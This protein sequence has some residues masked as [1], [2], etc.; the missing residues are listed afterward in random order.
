M[1]KDR[2]ETRLAGG[3]GRER[4][5]PTTVGSVNSDIEVSVIWLQFLW[6]HSFLQSCYKLM[7][8]LN[9]LSKKDAYKA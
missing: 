9:L 6:S 2:L 1:E 5:A 7:M 8:I 4:D 3:Q